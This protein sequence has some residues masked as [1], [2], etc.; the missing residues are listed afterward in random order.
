M[1]KVLDGSFNGVLAILLRLDVARVQ[2]DL[3]ASLL[4][5][6]VPDVFSVLLFLWQVHDSR[7]GAFDG[8][9]DRCGTT[10]VVRISSG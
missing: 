4:L 5:D 7:V 10:A 3:P 9:Q 6:I 8:K 1:A 2:K